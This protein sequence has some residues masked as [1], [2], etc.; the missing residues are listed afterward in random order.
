M[1]TDKFDIENGVLIYFS[2]KERTTVTVPDGVAEIGEHAF[3]ANE[4]V[5]EVILPQGITEIGEGAFSSCTRLKKINLPDTLEFIADEAFYGCTSLAEIILPSSLKKIGENAFAYC[6]SLRKLTVPGSIKTISESAFESCS[7]IA[8]LTLCEGIEEIERDAFSDCL[9]ISEL[10]LPSSVTHIGRGAFCAVGIKELVLHDGIIFIG[11]DAFHNCEK[12]E[13][14]Y[15]GKDVEEIGSAAFGYCSS[16]KRIEVA[17]ENKTFAVKGNCLIDIQSKTL[18][19]ATPDFEI[20]ADGGVTAFGD[21]AFGGMKSLRSFEVPAFIEKIEGYT[22]CDCER[23]RKLTVHRD[24][25]HYIANNDCLIEVATGTLIAGC[26]PDAIPT[27]GSVKIIAGGAFSENSELTALYIPEGVTELKEFAFANFSALRTVKLPD[28]LRVIGSNAFM[29]CAKLQS[30]DF[31]A[32]LE[33]IDEWAFAGCE[34]LT[35]IEFPES[36]RFIGENAFYK[37]PLAVA[38]FRAPKYWFMINWHEA[39]KPIKVKNPKKAA[40]LFTEKNSVRSFE[41]KPK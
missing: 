3:V 7:E 8:E 31:G 39:A 21:A 29:D 15:I 18:L 26:S 10:K 5:T 16:L 17:K 34:E 25:K 37:V 2:D 1:I 36:L 27:D 11:D 12:L 14:I 28:S 9:K 38:K 19:Q 41:R 13:S 20:P 40:A 24:N 4:I 6:E 33:K 23:L 32:G 35:Q 22:F 30:L